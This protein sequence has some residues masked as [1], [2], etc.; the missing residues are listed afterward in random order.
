MCI[1][2]YSIKKDNCI[3]WSF[4]IRCTHSFLVVSNKALKGKG[5]PFKSNKCSMCADRKRCCYVELIR[6]NGKKNNKTLFDQQSIKTSHGQT[7]QAESGAFYIRKTSRCTIRARLLQYIAGKFNRGGDK[8]TDASIFHF[9][10]RNSG[11]LAE[12]FSSDVTFPTI[13]FNE[14]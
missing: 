3:H 11:H 1:V 2:I 4:S 8:L 14:M 5:C 13:S 12:V 6:A 9:H 10:S 7:D